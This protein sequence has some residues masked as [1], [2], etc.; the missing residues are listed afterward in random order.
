MNSKMNYNQY[1]LNMMLKVPIYRRIGN[2]GVNPERTR[3]CNA[4]LCTSATLKGKAYISVDAESEDLPVTLT[5]VSK[6]KAY[7]YFP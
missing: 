6:G 4:E 2:R 1:D 3:R 5:T 7:G